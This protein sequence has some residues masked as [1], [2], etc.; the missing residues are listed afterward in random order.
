MSKLPWLTQYSMQ[1]RNF[2]VVYLFY[3]SHYL[4]FPVS[5]AHRWTMHSHRFGA[6]A[7]REVTYSEYGID[8]IIVVLV[9]KEYGLYLHSNF[10]AY[11]HS[12]SSCNFELIGQR[13]TALSLFIHIIIIFHIVFV[14]VYFA[15]IITFV[16]KHIFWYIEPS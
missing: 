7:F 12:S 1:F 16:C 3:S 14:R 5:V 8:L 9:N 15:Y 2:K 10:F 6:T 4:P 13:Y 11:F